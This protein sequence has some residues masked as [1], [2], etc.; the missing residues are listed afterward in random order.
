MP[1]KTPLRF[2]LLLFTVWLSAA[3][4]F[5]QQ[6][7]E[8]P[9]NSVVGNLIGQSNPSNAV[10]LPH[11]A[12]ALMLPGNGS[13]VQVPAS[14]TPGHAVVFGANGNVI[15][16]GGGLAGSGTVSSVTCGT[17]LSGGAITTIGTCA[18]NISI[19][20]QGRL[21]LATATPVMTSSVAG[22]TSVIVTP[23]AGCL[24]PI[25]DGTNM[26]PTCFSEVSQATTD[27]TKSPTAVSASSVY[28]I[29]CWVDSGTNRCTRGPAWINSTTR[30]YTL[31]RINGI[32][33]NTSSITNG[34][35]AL[36][37][38]W[39]GTVASNASSTLD[40]ILGGSAS[41]GSAAVLNVFNAYNRRM[42]VPQ[43]TDTHA[44]YTYSSATVRQA[45][46]S[47]GNQISFLVGAAEDG[48]SASYANTCSTVSTV[49]AICEFGIGLDAT[50]AFAAPQFFY[51]QTTGAT[52]I[53]A[54]GNPSYQFMPSLGT[55]VLSAN[56]QGDSTHAN[57]FNTSSGGTLTAAILM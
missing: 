41:G 28:D 53:S 13:L 50:N 42:V 30:G 35:A 40:Y 43:V 47:A 31:T 4:A 19:S 16:D 55:H 22:A 8:L 17:G 3:P 18:L 48:V 45:N 36:R 29:F 26:V 12:A 27:T 23:Y 7:L 44:G 46:N 52:A 38:T 37:G 25:F 2:Y 15:A 9:P 11:L 34:P 24:I 6:F 33:L 10:D 14:A 39:L 49:G 56:E 54:A 21:T 57:T 32:L 51:E 1:T 5:G 20:P